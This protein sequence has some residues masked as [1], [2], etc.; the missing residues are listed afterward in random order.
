MDRKTLMP[1]EEEFAICT[2]I[3][4]SCAGLTFREASVYL[5]ACHFSDK[6]GDTTESMPRRSV[7]SL[8]K[9]AIEKI[10]RC[11][12]PVLDMIRPYV[13]RAPIIFFG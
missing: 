3:L 8:K 1:G 7:Y 12:E 13:E 6:W 2:Y 9:K 5:A 10:E 4:Q 11:G